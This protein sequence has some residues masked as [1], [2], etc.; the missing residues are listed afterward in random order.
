MPLRVENLSKRFGDLWALRDVSL[1]VSDGEVFGIFGTTAAGKTTLLNCIAGNTDPLSGTI[2]INSLPCKK[3]DIRFAETWKSSSSGLF[4]R[5]N[6]KMSD[7]QGRIVRFRENLAAAK[8]VAIFDEPFAAIDTLFRNELS[9]ELR[10][11]AAKGR[12]ILFAS[13]DFEQIA[14]V[15]DRVAVIDAGQ[16]QQIGTPQEVYERP[17]SIAVAS[18]VGVNNLMLARRLTSSTAEIPEF[19]TIDGEH[20]LFAHSAR[21]AKLGAINSN[22]TLAV[23]PEQLSIS[24][25]ASFPE[26]NLLKAVVTGI[27]FL[28]PTTI[29]E[30][31]AAGLKLEA[32][33]FRVVGLN[34]GDECMIAIPPDRLQVLKN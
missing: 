33:V 8:H 19:I 31:D 12:I 9:T 29:V 13:S 24:F 26:D 20:R 18:S 28:G 30:L 25:G 34:L 7:G 5:K 27:R 4:G 10:T 22:V 6:I 17:S 1:D 21:I 11:T 2:S 32:R 23:H 15:C 3:H 14:A 16:I